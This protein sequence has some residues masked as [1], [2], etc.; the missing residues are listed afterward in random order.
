MKTIK[1]GDDYW[2]GT[3]NNKL[4][5]DGAYKY[6]LTIGEIN[7]EGFVCIITERLPK[8]EY[9]CNPYLSPAIFDDPYILYH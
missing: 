2:D 6:K 9:E 4:L 1:H 5:P 3:V 8:G 7:H